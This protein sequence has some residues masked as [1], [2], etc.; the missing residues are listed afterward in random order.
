MSLLDK[1]KG[2]REAI[3]VNRA[4]MTR[5]YKFRPGKTVISVLPAH[6]DKPEDFFRKFGM[7]YLKNKKDEFVVAVGDRSITYGEECPVRDGLVEMIRYAN[8]IGDDD[9]AEKAKKSLGK[10]AYLFNGIVH[11]DPDKKAIE[12]PQL[13]QL[14]ESL[15]DQFFSIL[16]EYIAEDST[17]L[18]GWNDRLL[19]VVEREGTTVTDTKYKIY[20]APKRLSVK[21]EVMTKA[22]NLDE[23]IAGQFAEGVQKALTFI[24]TTT[25]RAVSGSAVASALTGGGSAALEAPKEVAVVDTEDLLAEAPAAAARKADAPALEKATTTDAVFEDVPT[26]APDDLLAEIDALAA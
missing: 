17:A 24:A 15:M 1:I 26:S 5:A 9:L 6:G 11:Q 13:F 14:S 7:H 23:Y 16:E 4:A 20:P 3:K 12:E 22:V 2:Q 8:R 19:F 10:P 21:P 18:L 25:G